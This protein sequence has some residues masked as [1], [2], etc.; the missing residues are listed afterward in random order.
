MNDVI[1]LSNTIKP[2]SDQLNA[3]DLLTGP[4]TVKITDVR[5][6]TVEQPVHIYIEGQQPYKPCKGM[7]R[8]LIH[9]WGKNGKE[10]I[11]K[12]ATLFCNPAVKWAGVAL[13]GI[14]ISHL[15]D[16]AKPSTMMLTKAR[17]RK[18]EFT[19]QPLIIESIDLDV[20]AAE[21]GYTSQEVCETFDPPLCDLTQVQDKANCA[22]YLRS[23][24]K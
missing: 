14:E 23:N 3:D 21:C 7:R 15:S 9:N 22:A 20:I 10:W 11:G 2:K 17:G 16:I 18:S 8:V 19:V 4:I 13:G 6:G 12:S 1:D 24:R 5:G